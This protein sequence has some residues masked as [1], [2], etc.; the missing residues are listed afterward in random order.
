MKKRYAIRIQDRNGFERKVP[1]G[2]VAVL[3]RQNHCDIVLPDEMVSRL[4]LRVESL[5]GQYWAE[6]MGSSHGTYQDGVR[7]KRIQWEPTTVLVI[8]DGAYRL[9]LVPERIQASESN[10]NAILSTA[11]QLSGDFDLEHLLQRS[12]DHL[13]RLSGQD[14]GFIMIEAG[15]KLE[16]FVQRN[17]VSG[18]GDEI[19]LSMSSVKHVFDTSEPIWI[20]DISTNEILKAQKSIADLQL[21]TILCL[22]L[23]VKGKNVGVVYLDSRHIMK[24]II[25]RGAF[26]A[27]VGLCALAIERTRLAEEGQRNRLLASVGSVASDIA[28]DFKNVLFL[29][30]GHAELLSNMCSDPEAHYHVEQIQASVDR[31]TTLSSEIL[32]MVRLGVADKRAVNLAQLINEEISRWQVY[33]KKNKV[34]ISGNGPDCIVYI[35]APKFISIIDNLFTNSIESLVDSKVKGNIRVTWELTTVG[36]TVKV[37]DNGKGISK[38]IINKIFDPFFSHGK[39]KGTGLGMATVK[40]FVELHNGTIDV[41]S[42]VGRGTSITISIPHLEEVTK[43]VTSPDSKD[44]R[45]DET[46][47]GTPGKKHTRVKH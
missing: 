26:E 43:V 5:D 31:L 7:I 32:G 8:A 19:Y 33:A 1:L 12:I 11:Q 36:V 21:K 29:I 46:M 2:N 24:D 18:S 39:A 25:D 17:L 35:D 10:M 37:S 3:G 14:R 28:H 34:V 6:D 22:P 4:H 40:N 13:L 47:R 44:V 42:Q 20:S 30:S 41:D 45:K 16:V 27:I 15:G 9:T 38:K 23:S